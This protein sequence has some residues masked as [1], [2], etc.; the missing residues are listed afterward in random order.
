MESYKNFNK[1]L[2]F[3]MRE[4]MSMYPNMPELKLMF[5]FYKIMKTV[6]KKSPQKY[7]YEMISPHHN[8]LINKNLGFFM[9]DDIVEDPVVKK[10]LGPLREEYLR[11]SQDN[12]DMIYNHIV[13]LYKLSLICEQKFTEPQ[14][15]QA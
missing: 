8:E 10:M 2:K 5:S 13:V 12:K 14:S 3:F 9:S 1:S 4:L 15:L 6:S 11:M 7:F